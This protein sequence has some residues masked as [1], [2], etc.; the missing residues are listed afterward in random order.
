MAGDGLGMQG[1]MVLSQNNQ[2]SVP[3]VFNQTAM[4]LN[5]QARM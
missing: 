4:S 5:D 1:A 3:Q 2:V